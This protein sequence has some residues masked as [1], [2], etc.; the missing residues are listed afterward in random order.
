MDN[1]YEES[2][3]YHLILFISIHIDFEMKY[4]SV[5]LFGF[6][7]SFMTVFSPLSA[8]EYKSSELEE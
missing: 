5:K 1:A 6:N 2:K 7:I 3:P 8:V 4:S